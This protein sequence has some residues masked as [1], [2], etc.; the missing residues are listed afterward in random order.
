M[1]FRCHTRKI[2]YLRNMQSSNPAKHLLADCRKAL[3]ES[4]PLTQNVT[5]ISA[6]NYANTWVSHGEIGPA[7]DGAWFF[8]E[9]RNHQVIPMAPL[10]QEDMGH[11]L[12]LKKASRIVIPSLEPNIIESMIN[13][14]STLG[15]IRN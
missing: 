8:G 15:A 11:I 14:R 5:V 4:P 12:A 2:S 9:P 7:I 13:I 1:A 3:K 6:V 10:Y